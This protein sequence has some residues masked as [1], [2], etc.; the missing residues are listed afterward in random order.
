MLVV[1]IHRARSAGNSEAGVNTVLQIFLHSVMILVNAAC[2]LN[3]HQRCLA[4][5]PPLCGRDL[6]E[7][8]GRIHVSVQIEDKKL[9]V[10]GKSNKTEAGNTV[11]TCHGSS[12]YQL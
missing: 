3:F 8:R 10:K 12:D 6:T 1:D 5:V 11:P 7:K 2:Y 4:N 9:T